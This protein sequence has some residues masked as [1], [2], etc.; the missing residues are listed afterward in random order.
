MKFAVAIVC[1]VVVAVARA[2]LT[3]EQIQKLK[4][5]HKDCAA[6]TGVDTELVTKARK[7][8]FSEDP[9][10]KDHLFCVAKKIGFMTADGE[11]HR[12]VLKEKL[13]SAIND[14]A[15]AQKLI[16]E[17]AVKKDTPQATAFDTIQCY[18]VKTP[19]HISIV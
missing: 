16:D 4:G 8:E 5:Y 11:I 9:K 17:C 3:E 2:S 19:T 7:G 14:D 12:D 15:A 6:E 10:F 1:L 13:G 18:Y